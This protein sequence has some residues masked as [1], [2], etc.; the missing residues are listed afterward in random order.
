MSVSRAARSPGRIGDPD[1]ARARLYEPQALVELFE[2][3]V[4]RVHGLAYALTGDGE[5][6]G[7]L[8]RETFIRA[9]D[10]L[11][12]VGRR[13]GSDEADW[14]VVVAAQVIVAGAPVA[15]GSGR[16]AR[17]RSALFALRA[18]EL[19][20]LAAH[21]VGGVEPR[22]LAV[23]GRRREW[24]VRSLLRRGLASAGLTEADLEELPQ[25]P[26]SEALR[27]RLLTIFLAE[28][29]QRRVG[30]VHRHDLRLRESHRPQVRKLHLGSALL[31]VVLVVLAIAVSVMIALAAGF[32]DPGSPLYGFKR[33]GENAL[34]MVTRSPV[35]RSNLEVS[36]A[37]QR[38]KEAEVMAAAGDAASTLGLI[39]SRQQDLLAAADQLLGTADRSTGWLA[40]RDRLQNE[41]AQ[42]ILGL[43]QA[44][45]D[46][47]QARAGAELT[48]RQA[49]FQSRWGKI[50]PRLATPAPRP[51]ASPA[52]SL[53]PPSP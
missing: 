39:G 9:L 14:L 53:P 34:L 47:G 18:A 41:A 23:A 3:G 49:A 25:P 8:T 2:Q 24:S 42:S 48:S 11:T 33:G 6:A 7:E 20:V 26:A 38:L 51:A 27:S 46:H 22:A 13:V 31:T 16:A 10:R 1:T 30:W 5:T 44:L 37:G 19:E 50:A 17:T 40:A 32:S 35:S 45:R 4:D 52:A 36:L 15:A 12:E 21:V 43:E 28:A 29:A